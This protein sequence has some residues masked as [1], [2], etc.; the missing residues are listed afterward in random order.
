[1]PDGWEP[2]ADA[3]IGGLEVG[4]YAVLAVLVVLIVLAT[5]RR[6]LSV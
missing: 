6:V 5:V 1:M 3:F 4:V 2:N